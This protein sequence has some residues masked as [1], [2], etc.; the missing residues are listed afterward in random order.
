VLARSRGCQL[1]SGG[2]GDDCKLQTRISG[3][4]NVRLTYKRH[5]CFLV[6]FFVMPIK[7]SLSA[8]ASWR[9]VAP[10]VLVLGTSAPAPPLGL[11][12]TRGGPQTGDGFAVIYKTVRRLGLQTVRGP[13]SGYFRLNK[14]AAAAPVRCARGGGGGYL[15][16][17]FKSPYTRGPA[18]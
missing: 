1:P 3:A 9:R 15:R 13:G 8:S 16:S 6:I 18:D 2:G 7:C 10:Q 5:A 4:S 17:C 11:G 12:G 14:T